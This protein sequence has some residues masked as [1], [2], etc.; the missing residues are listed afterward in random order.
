MIL[1]KFFLKSQPTLHLAL[2]FFFLI[3][4]LDVMCEILPKKTWVDKDTG[5]RVW[6]L[7]DEENSKSL[8]FNNNAFTPDGKWMV[9]SNPQGIKALNL[10][11]KNSKFIYLPQR[12]SKV[13]L[14]S[15]GQKTNSIFIYVQNSTNAELLTIDITSG[16]VLN[17]NK[18]ELGMRI[19]SIN[20]NEKFAAGTFER[21][22]NQNNGTGKST[23]VYP[24]TVIQTE[25]RGQ[26]LYERL[27]AKIPL[28]LFILNLETGETKEIL[29]SND[30]LNHLQFSPTDP[31]LL[32]Y[33]HEGPWHKVQRIWTIKID[34]TEK[35]LMHHR[36][37]TMEIVG[38]EFWS[39]DGQTIWFDWQ[40]PKGKHFFLAG[41]SID[42][43]KKTAFSIERD[44]WAVHYNISN[45][46]SIF[47]GD[48]SD[49]GQA[50]RAQNGRWITS[51]SRNKEMDNDYS[52]DKAYWQ[53][54]TLK[55]ERLVNMSA[56]DYKLEPNVRVSPDNKMVIFRSNMFGA[57]YIFGVEL[58]RVKN[59]TMDI[60]DTVKLAEKFKA[61]Q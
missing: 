20:A 43:E 1:N 4:S 30:W 7:T 6:R 50:A 11:S 17:K 54:S 24:A 47:V 27:A 61:N 9:Y 39:R 38:H 22:E 28:S 25:R 48:G 46:G 52:N 29:K 3:F 12:K 14:I 15:V 18:I 8:Y 59:E 26:L 34:G 49:K 35:K 21:V 57:P 10:E 51:F 31:D 44:D 55:R 40:F 23:V 5:H 33:C 36:T 58:G 32:M 16:S 45:D 56:H 53:H 2:F 19:E 13:R 42:D 60:E 37:M 41:I